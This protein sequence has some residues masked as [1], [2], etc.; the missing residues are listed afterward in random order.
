MTCLI[1]IQVFSMSEMSF[2]GDTKDSKKKRFFCTTREEVQ[3][4]LTL[5]IFVVGNE[6][7][8]Y[9]GTYI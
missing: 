4:S 2:L 9:G 5:N 6:K 8:F 3:Q 1:Q 7:C